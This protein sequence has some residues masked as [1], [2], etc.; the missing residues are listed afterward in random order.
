MSWLKRGRRDEGEPGLAEAWQTLG[1]RLGLAVEVSGERSVRAKGTVRGRPVTVEINGRQ[2]G[3]E[4]LQDLAPTHRRR[5]HQRWSTELTV[6]C[7]NPR[8]LHGVLESIRDIDDPAWD[9]RNFD[10]SHCR[11]VRT[12]PASLAAWV[13]TPSIHERMMGLQTD[14]RIHVDPAQIRVSADEKTNRDGGYMVGSPIHN[15]YPRPAQP[16]P[17]R[18]LA[19]PPWWIDLLCD[20]ADAVD[21]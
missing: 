3:T 5:V 12:D 18:A 19:G 21:A 16:W 20:I 15:A 13:V 8:G 6:G 4:F 1:D 10:M 7:T 9:P 14:H 17:E 2:R 11:V